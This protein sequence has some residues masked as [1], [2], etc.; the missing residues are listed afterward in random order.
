MQ[1]KERGVAILFQGGLAP[2]EIGRV[3]CIQGRCVAVGS[4]G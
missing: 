1:A 4:G 2:W 3:V